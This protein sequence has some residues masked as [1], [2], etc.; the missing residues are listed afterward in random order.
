VESGQTLRSFCLRHKLDPG[1]I[2]RLERGRAAPPESQEILETY[3]KALKLKQGSEQWHAFM[4]AAAAERGRI[5]VDLMDDEVIEKLPVLFR[6]LRD[7]KT[8]DVL[9]DDLI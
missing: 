1:N 8:D 7:A 6:A 5:P 4:D 3:A 9:L 2:S